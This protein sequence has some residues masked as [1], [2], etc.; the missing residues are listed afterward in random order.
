MVNVILKRPFAILASDY[1]GSQ[2]ENQFPARAQPSEVSKE[3]GRGSA[4]FLASSSS[5]SSLPLFV[6]RHVRTRELAV[7]V[8]GPYVKNGEILNS[9][10]F[11]REIAE[12][13]SIF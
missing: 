8:S 10:Y 2:E 12:F 7:S 11:F 9:S 5:S 6:G 4:L 1:N 13:S 3:G